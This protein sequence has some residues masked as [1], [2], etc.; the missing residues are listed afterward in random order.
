[1]RARA[2]L[3]VAVATAVVI[4]VM[5]A[6]SA[7]QGAAAQGSPGSSAIPTSPSP[8]TPVDPHF[9]SGLNIYITSTGFKPHWLVAPFHGTIT[10]HN[11]TQRPQ[12]VVFDHQEVRS[13]VIPPGG[14]FQYTPSVP[15]SMTYHS[16]L[17]RVRHGVIQVQS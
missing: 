1:M 7:A 14:T 10:W 11:D 13:G 2:R 16:G 15:I 9:D 4:P 6:C 8:T 17:G 12:T 3:C 5:A